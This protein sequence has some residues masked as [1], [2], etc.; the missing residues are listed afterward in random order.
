MRLL[1]SIIAIL[2]FS[3]SKKS[4]KLAVF[5]PDEKIGKDT[6]IYEANE[7][8]NYSTLD[9]IHVLSL[10]SV[11]SIKNDVRSLIRFGFTSLEEGIKID[12]AFIYLNAIE[13]GHFGKNN[14]FM[15]IP[16][17]N[18]WINSEVNW[19][20]QPNYNEKNAIILKSPSNP[21]QNYKIDV[22]DYVLSVY[23]NERPNYGFLLKLENE[24]KSYKGLR[25]HSSNSKN[26]ELHPK[27]EIYYH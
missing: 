12:S 14:S 13:P 18:V 3:C 19:E 24:K 1:L 21:Y 23:K 4:A 11:D 8:A 20:N 27:L 6:A 17:D 5:K 25:F 7:S 9:R 16:V 2:F 15:L 22:T 26:K 10:S